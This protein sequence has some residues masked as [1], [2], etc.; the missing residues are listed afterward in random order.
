MPSLRTRSITSTLTFTFLTGVV[1]LGGAS[2]VW[3]ETAY[4]YWSFWTVNQGSWAYAN[5]GPASVEVRDGDAF[6][7]RFGISTEQGSPEAAPR[8]E[9]EELFALACAGTSPENNVV[10]VAFILDSGEPD[11]APG[12][13]VA[14]APRL[15]CAL[16][17]QG[18]TSAVALSAVAEL[19]VEA[20]FVCGVDGYPQGECAPAIELSDSSGIDIAAN[21]LT[22]ADENSESVD[23]DSPIATITVVLI[24]AIAAAIVLF[25]IRR[26]AR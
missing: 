15:A 3:A 11:S 26:R 23:T 6:G 8:V 18:S 1:W 20:G 2:P 24:G 25:V 9:A 5:V 4:R 19:R 22:V 10:R 16:V 17:P 21:P 14:P 13:Q 7:W 12:G